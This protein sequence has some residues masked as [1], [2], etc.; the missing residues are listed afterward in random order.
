MNNPDDMQAKLS[1]Q[2]DDLVEYGNP[3]I[4]AH[5]RRQWEP[6]LMQIGI[7]VLF[8]GV[9]PRPGEIIPAVDFG[10]MTW[11]IQLIDNDTQQR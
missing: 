6:I 5:V 4:R 8:H 7:E 9:V 3:E 2:H 10:G 1:L 11:T